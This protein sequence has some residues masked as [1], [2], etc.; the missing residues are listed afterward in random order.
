MKGEPWLRDCSWGRALAKGLFMKGEPWLR[1][2]SWGR[3]LAKGLFMEES[4][5]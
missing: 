1:D 2:C 5:G 3:S 4:L